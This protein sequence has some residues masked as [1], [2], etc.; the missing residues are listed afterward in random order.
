MAP[1]LAIPRHKA[2]KSRSVLS[3]PMA[4][5]I[6]AGLL[7]P[8]HQ[9]LDYGCGRGDDV[10]L[11]REM[12]YRSSGYDP[13]YFPDTPRLRVDVVTLFYVLNA[14]E[15]PRERCE[16]LCRACK[17]A[18]S[19]LIVSAITTRSN[20]HPGTAWGDG[21][22]AQWGTFEKCY[23]HAELKQ[24]IEDTLG[25]PARYIAQN[26]YTA[27][28]LAGALPLN[29]YRTAPSYLKKCRLKLIARQQELSNGWIPPADAII[30]K[31]FTTSRGKRYCYF[32]LKSR[33]RSL[34]GDKLTAHLGTEGSEAYLN[35]VEA[36]KRRD[37]LAINERRL[38]R[39]EAI[40]EG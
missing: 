12:G 33:S 21:T 31:H 4:A 26:T 37:L 19:S 39:I 5:A 34:R 7:Q 14:I 10:R 6:A 35:A 20:N 27:D 25:V 36:I 32:R 3:H 2:A 16:V 13:Y 28:R 8:H 30:E 38:L 22:I 24:L 29:L 40:M 9:H 11:L 18:R 15:I 17:L 1:N 23:S